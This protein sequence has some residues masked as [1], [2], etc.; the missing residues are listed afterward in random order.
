MRRALGIAFASLSLFF[1]CKQELAPAP[2]TISPQPT[3]ASKRI[4]GPPGSISGV[5]TFEG[6]V[7]APVAGNRNSD[8][9]CARAKEGAIDDSV[10]VEAGN[11]ANAVVQISAGAPGEAKTGSVSVEQIGCSYRP[12]IQSA[13]KGQTLAIRNGDQTLHNVHAFRESRTLFNVAQPTAAPVREERLEMAGVVRLKC[14]VHP[15]MSAYVVV[16]D[17]AFV[18]VTDAKGTF[19]LGDVP[20]GA[21]TLQ[22]WHEKLGTRT[23]QVTVEPGEASSTTFRFSVA[24]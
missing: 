16:S 18:A 11:L 22:A 10:L 1:A 9:F 14:D 7:P 13:I 8:P 3:V 5:V 21:Y 23:A 12:R 24:K 17:N 15:W 19:K 6:P 2:I 20:P 4:E